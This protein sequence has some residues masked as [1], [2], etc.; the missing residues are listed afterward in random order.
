MSDGVADARASRHVLKETLSLRPVQPD[1]LV[2][3]I[4]D[5]E[6][7]AAGVVEVS[8]V[9][10]H[11]RP[12]LAIVA[13]R[14]AGCERDVPEAAVALIAIELVRLCV[15]GDEDVRPAVL[16]V[17]EQRDTERLR[18]GVEDAAGRGH[19]LEGAVAAIAEQPAGLAA[20][21][22]R[23]A[24]RLLLAVEAAEDV[25]L[26]RPLHV[27]A[28]EQIEQAVAIEVQPHRRRAE[29]HA[30]VQTAGFRRVHERA[31]AGVAEQ[32]VLADAGDK[33][34]GEAVVV[35][36]ADGDAHAV[37][38]DVEACGARDVGERAVPVVAI[39]AQRRSLLLVAGPVHAVDEQDVLPAVGVVVEERA[40][41]RRV[42]RAAACRRRRRCCDGTADR[43][44]R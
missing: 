3:E 17:I 35:E 29:G 8:R 4:G 10:P 16:I 34:V 33:H 19:V 12:R 11:A 28:D 20:V 30:S 22:L 40:A 27:V 32:P 18:A 44:R 24:V 13:E 38:L 42:S 14:D 21:R 36:V 26:G 5:G 2:V 9:D 41:R 25:V 39:E 7:G 43:R 31:L 37:Q 15:V 1:H 23:R 6:A